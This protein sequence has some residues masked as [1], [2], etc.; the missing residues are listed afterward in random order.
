MLAVPPSLAAGPRASRRKTVNNADLIQPSRARAPVLKGRNAGETG[1]VSDSG[2]APFPGCVASARRRSGCDPRRRRARRRANRS[3]IL[4]YPIARQRSSSAA[5]AGAARLRSPASAGARAARTA[6][7]PRARAR[8]L[9][10]VANRA[11]AWM[12]EP[13]RGS[14]LQDR[15]VVRL[16]VLVR[17][18]TPRSLTGRKPS[19][20]NAD[21]IRLT[22]RL[23][24][25]LSRRAAWALRCSTGRAGTL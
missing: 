19:G 15:D 2:A 9:K 25:Q 24:A 6:S 22:R 14:S 13:S 11:P 1:P 21:R 4:P 17:L 7:T 23:S 20:W 3:T 8:S 16:L 5:R 18:L 10:S 12:R